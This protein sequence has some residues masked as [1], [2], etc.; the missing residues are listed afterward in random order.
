[1]DTDDDSNPI[2]MG[3]GMLL[4]MA[5]GLVLMAGTPVWRGAVGELCKF[6]AVEA[7]QNGAA[8][9]VAAPRLSVN[10]SP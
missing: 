1:M 5:I 6:A 9:C 3:S 4:G 10:P 7:G 2:A 8:A